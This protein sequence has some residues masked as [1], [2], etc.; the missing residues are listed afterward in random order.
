MIDNHLLIVLR[1]SLTPFEVAQPEF[2]SLFS[3]F[4]EER[5]P[6]S[7]A[8]YDTVRPRHSSGS[9]PSSSLAEGALTPQARSAAL[10]PPPDDDGSPLSFELVVDNLNAIT[11]GLSFSAGLTPSDAALDRFDALLC[12]ASA[13]SQH[14][15]SKL[16]ARVDDAREEIS[17]MREL[18]TDADARLDTISQAFEQKRRSGRAT[19]QETRAEDTSSE[20]V[21]TR[22]SS[23]EAET[24]ISPGFAAELL[25]FDS[26]ENGDGFL[27]P[28]PRTRDSADT[29]NLPL[30]QGNSAGSIAHLRS[31][32]SMSDLRN[33]L[34]PLFN[35]DGFGP[36]S[37]LRKRAR[38]DTLIDV[39]TKGGQS[40]QPPGLRAEGD[41]KGSRLKAWLRRTFLQERMPRPSAQKL[42]EPPS[43]LTTLVEKD[44]SVAVPNTSS[45]PS[46]R[47]LARVGKDLARIAGYISKVSV[48][49]FIND[50][51]PLTCRCLYEQADK[52]ITSAQRTIGRAERKTRRASQ[53]RCS[54]FLSSCKLL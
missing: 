21:V 18:W 35:Q 9:D 2:R 20:S 14:A 23:S 10:S 22:Q 47:V 27:T 4:Q 29:P 39:S 48:L 34:T 50:T 17:R 54:V 31:H 36:T 53:V 37:K 19:S 5:R 43:S 51:R 3:R 38:A 26:S 24:P 12:E 15:V 42:E 6:A 7:S 32:K 25:M 52:L 33:G 40:R 28:W 49:Y 46:D 1:P 13:L 30:A 16:Y 8:S 44:E 45:H 41:G 11:M